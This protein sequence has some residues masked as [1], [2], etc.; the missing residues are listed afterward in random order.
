MRIIIYTSLFC[1]SLIVMC[2]TIYALNWAF[3]ISLAAFSLSCMLMHR[4]RKVCEGDL[5]ELFGIGNGF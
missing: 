4:D 5:D 1:V 3:W 2:A